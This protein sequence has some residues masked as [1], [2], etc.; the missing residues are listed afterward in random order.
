MINIPYS[1]EF[2]RFTLFDA[3]ILASAIRDGQVCEESVP[4]LKNDESKL[5]TY[6]VSFALPF[7]IAAIVLYIVDIIVRKLKWR[8]IVT[9]LHKLK[10][11]GGKA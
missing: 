2:D 4:T 9:L 8:D 7:M 3:S 1:P 11:K 6:T 5:A 10:A